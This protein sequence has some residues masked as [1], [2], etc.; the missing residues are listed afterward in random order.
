MEKNNIFYK[1]EYAGTS[2]YLKDKDYDRP[3]EYFKRVAK[4][5]SGLDYPQG[6]KLLDV[7]CATGKLLYYIKKT[8]PSFTYLAGMDVSKVMIKEAQ[9]HVPGVKFFVGSVIDKKIFRKRI[10]N[11]VTC[12]GVLPIFDDPEILLNNLLSCVCEGGTIIIFNAFNNDPVDVVMRY[13]RVDVRD[14]A[15]KKGLN[16]FSCRTVENILKNSGYKLRWEW[17]DFRMPFAIR[18]DTKDSLRA[19]TMRTEYD[20]HQ[21]IN[22]A[23]QLCNFKILCIRILKVQKGK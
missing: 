12:C 11:A 7:G 18:K 13:S 19:W 22:G 8:L 6:L 4:L 17:H 16:M 5:L 1:G 20:S 21:Q 9:R 10:Y 3:K 15:W 23:S 14:N 2:V